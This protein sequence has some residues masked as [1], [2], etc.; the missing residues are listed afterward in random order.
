MRY[1]SISVMNCNY[2]RAPGNTIY[3]SL[4]LSGLE[5]ERRLV[6]A[7]LYKYLIGNYTVKHIS[8]SLSVYYYK[9]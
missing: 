1:I 4:N 6:I 2:W 5:G 9:A 3:L 7:E 8:A